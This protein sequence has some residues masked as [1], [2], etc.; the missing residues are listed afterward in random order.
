MSTRPATPQ[1]S[2]VPRPPAP[3]NPTA[4]ESSTIVSAPWRSARSQIDFKVGDDAV[5]R[6]HAVGRDQREAGSRSLRF[7]EL[8]LEIGHVVVAVAKALR[9]AEADAVDDA[10]VIQFVAD[11]GILLA[12]QRLEEPAVGVEA[13]PVQDGGV[14]P[15]KRSERAFERRVDALRAADEAHRRHSEAVAGEPF[16]GGT[17]K[18]RIVGESQVVVG[19]EIEHPRPALELDLG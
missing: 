4:C 2:G 11:H 3:T 6:E 13:A 15:E 19:A 7:P 8:R 1:C 14:G 18:P 12:E 16:S 5:H 9:L 17:D 10:R